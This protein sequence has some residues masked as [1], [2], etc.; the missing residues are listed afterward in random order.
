MK[1]KNSKKCYHNYE[2]FIQRG[3]KYYCPDCGADISSRILLMKE[4]DRL[5]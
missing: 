2:H 4:L 3:N 1:K 5:I